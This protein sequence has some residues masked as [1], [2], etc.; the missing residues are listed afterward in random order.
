MGRLA[1]LIMAGLFGVAVAGLPGLAG[2]ASTGVTALDFRFAGPDGSAPAAV[3]INPGDAVTFAYPTGSSHHDVHFTGSAPDACTGATAQVG[4]AP[5]PAAPGWSATCTFTAP[6]VYAFV[7]D[8]HPNMTGT[9]TVSA[10]STMSP[11][12]T[13]AT[14]APAGPPP[15]PP[16]APPATMTPTPTPAAKPGPAASALKVAGVQ[17]GT[18]VHGRVT[19]ARAGSSLS[20]TLRAG[21]VTLGQLHRTGL[22]AGVLSIAV[23]VGAA[24]RRSLTAHG[25][26]ALTLS[27]KVTPRTGA[28]RTLSHPVILKP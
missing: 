12:T 16:S 13:D 2:A 11:A 17:H 8:V 23:P 26:L 6:G 14:P 4:P 7:C 18:A 22:R 19:I 21:T 3:A 28:A 15:T 1:V 9:V 25:R 5:A 27:V 20:A 10:P 24:G